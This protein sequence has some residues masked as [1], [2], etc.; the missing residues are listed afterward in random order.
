[1]EEIEGALEAGSHETQEEVDD[2]EVE[3]WKIEPETP[4]LAVVKLEGKA[5]KE[6]KEGVGE[7]KENDDKA[8]YILLPLVA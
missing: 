3:E 8:E 2:G 7:V 5:E 4:S 6:E 1:M